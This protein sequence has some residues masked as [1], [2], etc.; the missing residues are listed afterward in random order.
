MIYSLLYTQH[1]AGGLFVE[2]VALKRFA[3]DD[4]IFKSHSVS[5]IVTWL[6]CL[7][8]HIMTSH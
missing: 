5:S 8:E 6:E 2:I 3:A 1:I 7:I 4:M